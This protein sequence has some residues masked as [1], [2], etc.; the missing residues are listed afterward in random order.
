MQ[1]RRQED[2][3]VLG[4][5]PRG[6]EERGSLLPGIG[7]ELGLFGQLSRGRGRG[8]FT[9]IERSRRDLQEGAA[10]GVT[11]L[12]DEGQALAIPRQHRNRTGM[13]EHLTRGPTSVIQDDLACALRHRA[14]GLLTPT[15]RTLRLL[16]SSSSSA[17]NGCSPVEISSSSEPSPPSSVG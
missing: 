5:E 12:A 13:L 6:G 2:R 11:P 15:S 4:A 8:L 17:T 7:F 3:Q 14:S 9:G 10:G 1:P 16:A